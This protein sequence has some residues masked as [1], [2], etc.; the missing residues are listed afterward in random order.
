MNTII[1][2][3][4]VCDTNNQLIETLSDVRPLGPFPPVNEVIRRCAILL[5]DSLNKAKETA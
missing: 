1:R 3:G 4:S 5:R 2:S